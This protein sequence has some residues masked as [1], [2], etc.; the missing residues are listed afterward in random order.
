MLITAFYALLCRGASWSQRVRPPLKNLVRLVRLVRSSHWSPPLIL[1]RCSYV[2]D[3]IRAFCQHSWTTGCLRHYRLKANN[4][5]EICLQPENNARQYGPLASLPRCSH[6]IALWP[7][8]FNQQ[9]NAETT[10][11]HSDGMNNQKY[12]LEVH[13]LFGWG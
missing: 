11:R 6:G 5:S 9:A 7:H 10:S 8:P 3:G 12:L 1:S 4:R 13:G 2:G